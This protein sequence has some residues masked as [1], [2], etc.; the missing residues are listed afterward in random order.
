MGTKMAPSYGNIFMGRLEKQ[1]L[2]SVTPKPLSWLRFIDDKDMKWIHGRKTLEAFLETENNF[3][4]TIGSTAEVSNVKHIFL[5]TTSHLV[6]DKVAVDLYTKPTDSHQYV[7]PTSCH[8]PHCSKNIPYS[9]ALR[10]RHICSDDEAFDKRV[11]DLSVHLN[12]RGNQKQVIDQAIEKVRH[13][14]RQNLLSYKPKPKAN[15]AV[16]PFVMA[17]HTDLP[18]V[19]G[20]VDKHWSII[21]SSDI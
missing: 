8:P 15:K 11:S 20:L 16:L 2:Q 10:I 3:I 4:P 1:L 7:L 5:D 13:I 14:H 21:E 6:D 19:R 9:P 18:K 12:K 17:Y